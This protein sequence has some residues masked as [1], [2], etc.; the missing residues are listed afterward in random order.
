MRTTLA[1]RVPTRQRSPL[2]ALWA[3]LALTI[4]VGVHALLD[5][6]TT[7][8]LVDHLR[9]TYPSYDPHEVDTAAGTY[10]AILLTV[11]ALGA[12]GWVSTIWAARTHRPWARWLASAYLAIAFVIALAGLTTVDTS[13]HVGLAPMMGWLLL[14]PCAAGVVAVAILWWQPEQSR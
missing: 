6:S 7:H 1:A 8:L 13:G 2:P 12:V 11:A 14:A 10:V 5:G 9:A 3:G 4:A